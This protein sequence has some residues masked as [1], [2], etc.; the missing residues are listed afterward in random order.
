MLGDIEPKEKYKAEESW[1]E[2]WRREHGGGIMEE[3][4]WERNYG[5]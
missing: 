3:V 4:S 2:S 1:G 5:V